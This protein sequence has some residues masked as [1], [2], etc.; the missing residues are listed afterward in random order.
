[1][2]NK[3]SIIISLL[4]ISLRVFAI[5]PELKDVVEEVKEALLNNNTLIEHKFGYSIKAPGPNWK[6]YKLKVSSSEQDYL[7]IEEESNKVYLLNFISRMRDL[8]EKRVKNFI[9]GAKEGAIKTNTKLDNISYKPTDNIH[10]S[11]FLLT[12]DYLTHDGELIYRLNTFLITVEGIMLSI[13]QYEDEGFNKT[14]LLQLASNVKIIQSSSQVQ[15]GKSSY[16]FQMGQ[17]IGQFIILLAVIAGIIFL[18][19]AVINSR[20]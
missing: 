16:Y 6:W 5:P 20:K 17:H 15:E 8:N 12:Y 14:E 13:S 2:I 9:E 18:I 7:L 3:R 19:K 11:S 1:M 4:F 10:K